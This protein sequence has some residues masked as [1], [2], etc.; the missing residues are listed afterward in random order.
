MIEHGGGLDRQIMMMIGYGN[1]R[2]DFT[3]FVCPGLQNN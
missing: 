1:Y 3:A 2:L